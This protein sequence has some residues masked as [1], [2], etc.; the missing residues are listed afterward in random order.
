MTS[1]EPSCIFFGAPG[2]VICSKSLISSSVKVL[3]VVAVTGALVAGDS[4]SGSIML[5]SKPLAKGGG[6]GEAD[7]ETKGLLI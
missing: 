5:R 2:M 7:Q 1:K 3:P 6:V 4:K